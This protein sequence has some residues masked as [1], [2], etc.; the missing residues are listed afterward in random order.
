MKITL[1]LDGQQFWTTLAPAHQVHLDFYRDTPGAH[2]PY[3]TVER[4]SPL[5]LGPRRKTQNPTRSPSPSFQ[6]AT[7]ARKNAA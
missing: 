2:T 4:G 3:A 5:Y 6:N 7:C 1:S